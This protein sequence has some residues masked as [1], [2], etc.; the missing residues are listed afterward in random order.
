MLQPVLKRIQ[1]PILG[2][3][4]TTVV[5]P[6]LEISLQSQALPILPQWTSKVSKKK[7]KT[8]WR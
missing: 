3:I 7:K 8:S 6:E 5:G 4:A 1:S 2:T